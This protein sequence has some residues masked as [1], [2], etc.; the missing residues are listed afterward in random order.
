[1]FDH[2]SLNSSCNDKCSRQI[3]KENQ[4]TNFMSNNFFFNI[5]VYKL[6]RTDVVQRG[7]PQMTIWRMCIACCIPKATNTHSGY[8]IVLPFSLQQWL[9]ERVP[10]LRNTYIAWVLFVLRRAGTLC[11]G[12]ITRSGESYRMCVCVIVS[13]M[14]TSTLRRPF[15]CNLCSVPRCFCLPSLKSHSQCDVIP[16][17]SSAASIS[18]TL[19]PK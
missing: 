7:R 19:N 1:M 17:K 9:H 12:I 4:T 8:V 18:R 2:I 6:M 11:Y 3:C 10:N 16:Y 13:N 5:T 15:Q 14:E